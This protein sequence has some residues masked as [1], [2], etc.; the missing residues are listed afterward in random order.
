MARYE[1]Q[2]G[3]GNKQQQLQPVDVVFNLNRNGA[4]RNSLSAEQQ[5]A[6]FSANDLV[7]GQTFIS[8]AIRESARPI[9]KNSV[10]V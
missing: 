9:I 3:S 6:F 10:A 5:G 7:Q 2:C 4:M 1:P 8:A